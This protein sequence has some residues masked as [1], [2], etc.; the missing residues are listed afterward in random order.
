MSSDTISPLNS[1][2][3]FVTESMAKAKQSPVLRQVG[4]SSMGSCVAVCLLNPINVIKVALQNSDSRTN[5]QSTVF[6][7][8]K[9]RGP[10][11]FWAG[12][13]VGL[14]HSVPSIVFYM[15][16]YERLKQELG[17][18]RFT[19]GIAAGVAR[20][21]SISLVA[22]IEMVRLVKTGGS[23][24][25]PSEIVSNIYNKEGI[26]GFYRGWASTVMRDVPYSILYWGMYEELQLQY[27]KMWRSFQ[28]SNGSSDNQNGLSRNHWASHMITFSAG[29][30][31]GVI[32]AVI[33]HPFDVLKTQ[34]QLARPIGT[35]GCANL[36]DRLPHRT[37]CNSLRQAMRSQCIANQGRCSSSIASPM[38]AEA[39]LRDCIGKAPGAISLNYAHGEK[40]SLMSST[41]VGGG[42]KKTSTIPRRTLASLYREGGVSALYRGLSMRLATVIPGGAIMVTVYEAVKRF[43]AA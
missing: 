43:D 4:A 20:F 23:S 30:T 2:V 26:R 28:V 11:G 22:P 6:R 14:M 19:P 31:A 37:Y 33:T 24:R 38:C 18:G 3:S 25:S 15:L 10:F 9:E 35:K 41:S 36:A 13:A 39:G 1:Y 17:R 42:R 12:T 40:S 32:A 29:S 21:F 27:T 5:I 16:T 34:Q 7:I 8:M